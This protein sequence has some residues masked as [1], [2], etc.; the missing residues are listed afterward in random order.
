MQIYRRLIFNSISRQK[1]PIIVL[2]EPA[3][4]YKLTCCLAAAMLC[5]SSAD[6]VRFEL[7]RFISIASWLNF[8]W[9]DTFNMYG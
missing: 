2:V 3:N 4:F 7:T 9:D 5:F 1:P 6:K 8:L